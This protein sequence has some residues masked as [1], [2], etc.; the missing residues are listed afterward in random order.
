M[1]SLP[2]VVTPDADEARRWAE[3]ELSRSV[4]ST[5]PGLV[6]RA[7]EWFVR[8]LERL[9]SLD[10][11]AP[12]SLVPLLLVVGVAVLL[13]VALYL[14]GP[15]RARRRATSASAVVFEDGSTSAQLTALADAAAAAGDWSRAVLMRF[16]AVVRALDERALLDD[17][18]GLTAHEATTAAAVR[19]P[20]L[21]GD[22]D[23]AGRLFDAVCYGHATP[24]PADDAGLRAL[25]EAV[26]RARSVPDPAPAW[27]GGR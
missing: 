5:E 7:W 4:Y 18:P 17:R 21:A 11:S 13:G 20:D 3:D 15:V 22:L 16:R 6:D 8:Q 14:S 26:G 2:L 12:S 23:R 9:L 24:G 1:P 19:L 27:A 25:A 10:A